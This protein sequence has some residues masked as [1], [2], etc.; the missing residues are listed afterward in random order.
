[1]EHIKLLIISEF[2]VKHN[3][4]FGVGYYNRKSNIF[5]FTDVL[6]LIKKK[7][8]FKNSEEKKLLNNLAKFSL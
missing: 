5:P 4:I 2:L 3:S 6:S 1:M 8:I 7:K